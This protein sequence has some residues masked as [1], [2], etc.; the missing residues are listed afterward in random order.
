MLFTGIG[1]NDTWNSIEGHL[2]ST[3]EVPAPTLAG[4][5]TTGLTLLLLIGVV[6]LVWRRYSN[7]D[8]MTLD[9]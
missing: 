8:A 2:V 5:G 6:L 1:S 4:E 9:R 3:A 7:A